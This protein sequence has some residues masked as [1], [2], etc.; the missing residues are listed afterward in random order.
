MDDYALDAYFEAFP[1]QAE[2]RYVAQPDAAPKV[3]SC[4]C[5]ELYCSPY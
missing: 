5:N 4:I 2:F 3:R 1:E